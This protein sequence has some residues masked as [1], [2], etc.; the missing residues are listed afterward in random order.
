MIE[1]K[2]LE[3]IKTFMKYDIEK[4]IYY[5]SE[6]EIL[7]IF[8]NHAVSQKGPRCKRVVQLDEDLNYVNDYES[9]GEA[10]R[11]L[12][13]CQPNLSNAVKARNIKCGGYYWEE[14]DRWIGH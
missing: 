7:D 14:Y 2:D 5:I 3:L 12:G 9:I 1:K 13:V 8:L 4:K 11:A 6:D 10:S